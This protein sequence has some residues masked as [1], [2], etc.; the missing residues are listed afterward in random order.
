VKNARGQIRQKQ[1]RSVGSNRAHA[2]CACGHLS[3]SC[4]LVRRL[5]PIWVSVMETDQIWA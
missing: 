2:K 4:S 5:A 1:F 3:R